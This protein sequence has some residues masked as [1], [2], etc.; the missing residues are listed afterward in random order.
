M[1]EKLSRTKLAA[2]STSPYT[3]EVLSAAELTLST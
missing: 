2:L 1:T 3:G